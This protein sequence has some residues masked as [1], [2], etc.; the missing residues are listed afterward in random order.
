MTQDAGTDKGQIAL[1]DAAFEAVTELYRGLEYA[2][3]D[4][5]RR[6]GYH[7]PWKSN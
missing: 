7:Q 5:S 2:I 1:A 4:P 6:V 3:K